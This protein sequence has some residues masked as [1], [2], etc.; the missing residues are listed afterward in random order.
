MSDYQS[1]A[2]SLEYLSFTTAAI[3]RGN[4]YSAGELFTGVAN[5]NTKTVYI[6]NQGNDTDV[7][8]LTP[9]VSSNG[10]VYSNAISNPTEDTQGDPA[11]V[12]TVST[13]GNSFDASVRTAGDN[14]TGII[15]GGNPYPEVTIGGGGGSSGVAV[16]VGTNPAQ[17][18]A[19]IE[20]DD[21]WA[22]EVTNESGNASDISINLSLAEVEAS[23]L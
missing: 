16:G 20:P 9:N 4:G 1:T 10:Q 6:D 8:V 18:A 2:R 17:I 3:S 19:I 23:E 14:E 11:T 22:V 12:Q 13:G 21:L 5:G 7:V 15:S